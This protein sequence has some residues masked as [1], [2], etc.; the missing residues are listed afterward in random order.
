[1]P[2]QIAHMRSNRHSLATEQKGPTVPPG[3]IAQLGI[4]GVART[5]A[6]MVGSEQCDATLLPQPQPVVKVGVGMLV[7]AINGSE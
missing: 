1:M 3:R 4:Q 2:P 6:D 5:G 7:V